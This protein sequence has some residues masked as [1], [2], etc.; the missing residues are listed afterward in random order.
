MNHPTRNRF[1]LA[2]MTMALAA[3]A[4]ATTPAELIAGYSAQ[5]GQAG[6]GR[7]RPAA[8]HDPPRP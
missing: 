2:A 4:H 8:V 3:A 7:A 5:A 1:A 6:R